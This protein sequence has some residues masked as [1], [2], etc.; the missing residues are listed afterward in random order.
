MEKA[1]RTGYL[2][3]F[4]QISEQKYKG[5]RDG[6]NSIP[7]YSLAKTC[8]NS[9]NLNHRKTVNEPREVGREKGNKAV[10]TKSKPLPYLIKF[11]WNLEYR[12]YGIKSK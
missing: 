12:D 7:S 11:R 6:P 10:I 9:D 1:E 3:E 5:R 2:L 8:T 4:S